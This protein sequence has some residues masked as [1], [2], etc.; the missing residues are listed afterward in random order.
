MTTLAEQRGSLAAII[1]DPDTSADEKEQA[2]IALRALAASK[3]EG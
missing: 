3:E 2:R 1:A